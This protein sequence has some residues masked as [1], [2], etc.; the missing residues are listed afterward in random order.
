MIRTSCVLAVG[1]VL[2]ASSACL[3]T[4]GLAEQIRA[5]NQFEY[6]YSTETEKEIVENWLDV[7]YLFGSFRTGLLLNNQQP[8]EEG[9]RDGGRPVP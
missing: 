3:G 4:G 5:T 8:A 2:T 7:S 1:L 9:T 6:S